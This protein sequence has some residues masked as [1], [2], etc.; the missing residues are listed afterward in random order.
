MINPFA[1][2]LDSFM[3]RGSAAVTVPPLDGALKPNNQ[4]EELPEGIAGASP[5]DSALWHG[6]PLYSDKNRLMSVSGAI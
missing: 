2:I 1:R 6:E 3:G 5:D 4:L